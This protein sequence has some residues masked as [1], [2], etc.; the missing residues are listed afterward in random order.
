MCEPSAPLAINVRVSLDSN[1]VEGS[2]PSGVTEVNV[3]EQLLMTNNHGVVH[4]TNVLSSINSLGMQ[5]ILL[6]LSYIHQY[7]VNEINAT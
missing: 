4:A 6:R 2:G 3:H 7:V 5:N 1:I